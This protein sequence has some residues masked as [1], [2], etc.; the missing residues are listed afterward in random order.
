ME[1]I[2]SIDLDSNN[3]DVT[4]SNGRYTRNKRFKM[5]KR[6]IAEKF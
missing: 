2:K 3:W 4:L 6:E 5:T 1:Q